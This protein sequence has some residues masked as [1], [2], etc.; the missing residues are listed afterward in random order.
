MR[1]ELKLV[2]VYVVS[3][4]FLDYVRLSGVKLLTHK[5]TSE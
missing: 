3:Q 5:H 1:S 2:M 4:N